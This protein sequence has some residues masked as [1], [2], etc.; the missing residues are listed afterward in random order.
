MLAVAE[1]PKLFLLDATTQAPL[2]GQFP[3]PLT[4]NPVA[5]AVV[6][7]LCVAELLLMISVGLS[8]TDRLG[9]REHVLY[10][11]KRLLLGVTACSNSGSRFGVCSCDADSCRVWV[12]GDSRPIT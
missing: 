8:G 10:S 1:P 5:L 9:Y 7:L 12:A 2:L 4:P 6:I 11:K 3:V